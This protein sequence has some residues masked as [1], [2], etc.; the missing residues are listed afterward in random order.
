MSTRLCPQTG[1][2]DDTKRSSSAKVAV[3]PRKS[4]HLEQ[5]LAIADTQ[6]GVVTTRQ[7]IAAGISSSSISFWARNG[8]PLA[9][10]LP[11]TY[12]LAS[13]PHTQ[14]QREMAAM[15]Y[16]AHDG[17][18]TGVC[19]LAH[20]G[21]RDL[22]LPLEDAPVHVLIPERRAV[23]SAG[24]VVI[25]RTRR[26]P[27]PLRTSPHPLAPPARALFDAA[28]RHH[29]HRSG[30]RAVVLEALRTGLVRPEHLATEIQ[31]GQR[32]WTAPLRGALADFLAG[33]V[34]TP[35]AEVRDGLISAG[36]TSFAWNVDLLTPR[37]EF[38]GR[39]DAYDADCGLALEVDSRRHHSE[40]TDWARTLERNSRYAALGIVVISIVPAR[41]RQD[42]DGVIRQVAQARQALA[43]RSALGVVV[44]ARDGRILTG[45]DLT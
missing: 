44:R 24:F 38:V 42:P 40:D 21:A 23:C 35:E 6:L 29:Q 31:E 17:Q 28:R 22:P 41:F 9:R 13:T 33:V 11:G 39:P 2:R 3:M 12:V 25:E 14:E 19:A 18:L 36:I 10:V 16:A 4:H 5:I 8:G 26:P 1:R 27:E 15:T 45:A 7:M 32:R 37:G 30:V 20:Y 43:G 34:S